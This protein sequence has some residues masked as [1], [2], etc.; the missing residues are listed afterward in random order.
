MASRI[1]RCIW[2]LC[3]KATRGSQ[4]N[5]LR[6]S[7]LLINGYCAPKHHHFSVLTENNL[8]KIYKLSFFCLPLQRIS[9]SL[10]PCWGI[11]SRSK[12]ITQ[13]ETDGWWDKVSRHN[14]K[15]FTWR[16]VLDESKLRNFQYSLEHCNG[17]CPRDVFISHPFIGMAYCFW[18][19]VLYLYREKYIHIGVGFDVARSTVLGNAKAS[20]RG[21]GNR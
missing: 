4:Q 19:W 20:I 21:T 17:R 5:Q 9:L 2:L 16:S 6:S 15:A 12:A 13:A 18:R 11:L 14:I 10:T 3:Y 1:F 8:R 7:W